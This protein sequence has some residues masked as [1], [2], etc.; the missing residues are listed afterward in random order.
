MHTQVFLLSLDSNT[1]G[2]ESPTL[3]RVTWSVAV[4]PGSATSM[5]PAGA[6]LSVPR[7]TGRMW[8][9]TGGGTGSHGGH[10]ILTGWLHCQ[11]Y[12]ENIASMK[13]EGK[14]KKGCPNQKT[15]ESS[16]SSVS[17]FE[18]RLMTFKVF[19]TKCKVN[20][21]P[22]LVKLQKTWASEGDLSLP[23]KGFTVCVSGASCCSLRFLFIF[24]TW[25]CRSFFVSQTGE[26]HNDKSTTVLFEASDN[27]HSFRLRTWTWWNS[28][29]CGL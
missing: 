1:V 29:T 9:M 2:R 28:W 27:H 14:K 6:T 4:V 25:Y 17:L 26:R 22:S 11:K 8:A 13:Q 19:F 23:L 15:V 21:T 7:W 24:S 5:C 18:S 20:P 3:G 16:C 12:T 10:I